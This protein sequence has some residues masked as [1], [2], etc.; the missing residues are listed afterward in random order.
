MNTDTLSQC[1]NLTIKLLHF[2][3]MLLFNWSR[4]S[5]VIFSLCPLIS[6]SAVDKPMGFRKVILGRVPARRAD[7][8]QAWWHV[9]V[10]WLATC[11]NELGRLYYFAGVKRQS[12]L[13]S[14]AEVEVCPK[15]RTRYRSVHVV[16]VNEHRVALHAQRLTLKSVLWL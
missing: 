7:N 3:I 6:P 2:N 5:T 16:N 15:Q 1:D 11:A 9:V 4:N 13:R 14:P 10:T 12:V 8:W